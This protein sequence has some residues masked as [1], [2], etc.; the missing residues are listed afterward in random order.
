MGAVGKGTRVGFRG[1]ALCRGEGGELE[2]L[3]LSAKKSPGYLA[4]P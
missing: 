4:G 2:P 3:A 1:E